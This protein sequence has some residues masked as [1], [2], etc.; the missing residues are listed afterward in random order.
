VGTENESIQ[1]KNRD[2]V[3]RLSKFYHRKSLIFSKLLFQLE[4]NLLCTE[5]ENRKIF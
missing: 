3:V 2:R 4:I 5:I 1:V